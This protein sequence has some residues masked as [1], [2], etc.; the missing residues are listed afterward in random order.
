MLG[1]KNPPFPRSMLEI[2]IQPRSNN[3]FCN[4]IRNFNLGEEGGGGNIL[5]LKS[6]KK[7][8]FEPNFKFS[9]RKNI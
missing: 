2:F 8:E 1:W 3:K 5:T 4:N 9:N 7:R 6:L